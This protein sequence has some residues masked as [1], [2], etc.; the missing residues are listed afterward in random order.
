MASGTAALERE[1]ISARVPKG[2][3]ERLEEA[4]DRSGATLSQFLV[5]AAIEKADQVLERERVM[6]LSARDSKRLLK[7][8]DQPPKPPNAKLREALAEYHEA[9][10]GDPNRP[11]DWPARP[12]EF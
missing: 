11:F 10:R 3:R 8:L 7:L 5:Q 6:R 4:A 12:D 9:T 2:V 1:R